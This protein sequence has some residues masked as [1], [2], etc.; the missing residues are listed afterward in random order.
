MSSEL[1]ETHNDWA[2]L[3]DGKRIHINDVVETGRKGYYCPGVGCNAPMQAIKPKLKRPYF[4]HDAYNV[5]HKRQCTYSNETYRHKI[6]KEILQRLKEI[7]VPAVWKYPPKD[8][9]GKPNSIADAQT[10]KAHSVKVE[11]SFYEDENSEVK[12]G[13]SKDITEKHL[14][15][16]PDVAFFDVNNRPIL[17]IEL[18]ATNKV[19]PEKAARLRRLGID[20]I[21]VKVPRGNEQEI[22][23]VFKRTSRTRWQFN[24]K[25]YETEYIHIPGRSQEELPEADLEQR[26]LFEE[27]FECRKADIGNLIR[28]LNRCLESEQYQEIERR[29]RSDLSRTQE[30]ARRATGEVQKLRHQIRTAAEHSTRNRRSEIESGR[31]SF[32]Q[33]SIDLEGRYYSKRRTLDRDERAIREAQARI[34]EELEELGQVPESVEGRRNQIE[35]RRKAIK[36]RRGGI[37]ESTEAEEVRRSEI[38]EEED[39]IAEQIESEGVQLQLKYDKHKAEERERFEGIERDLRAR[40]ERVRHTKEELWSE[41][42]GGFESIYAEE[43]EIVQRALECIQR[44]DFDTNIPLPERYHQLREARRVLNDIENAHSRTKLI[45]AATESIDK[46][47]Y[48]NWYSRH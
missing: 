20:T 44:R 34:E 48:K 2:H 4:R 8:V 19:D 6:A 29:L 21:S 42:K 32:N 23:R 7:K 38:I 31:E 22:E 35:E 41:E 43:S 40:I 12:W 33:Q 25:E 28:S 39:N 46:K 10:I 9:E 5:D 15:I 37:T 30:S 16:R 11:L 18:I 13:R 27:T 26:A 36:R 17:L 47:T 3:E 14:L 24:K 1:S 45:I